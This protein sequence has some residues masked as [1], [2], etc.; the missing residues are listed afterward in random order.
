MT[1]KFYDHFH[2]KLMNITLNTFIVRSTVCVADGIKPFNLLSE[3]V[4]LSIAG[5]VV[6]KKVVH[7]GRT[8]FFANFCRTPVFST[9]KTK[10]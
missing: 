6:Y 10:S 9:R 3:K 1:D 7:F 4:K 5:S 8:Q 2:L